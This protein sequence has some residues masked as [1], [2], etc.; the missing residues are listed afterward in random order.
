MKSSGSISPGLVH[1]NCGRRGQSWQ[2]NL[3]MFNKSL[4][5]VLLA[6]ELK[7][8][9]GHEKQLR[10]GTAWQGWSPWRE[11]TG[12]GTASPALESLAHLRCQSCGMNKD[13]CAAEPAWGYQAGWLD[14]RDRQRCG[15]AKAPRAQKIMSPGYR[16]ITLLEFGFAFIVTVPWF[17]LLGIRKV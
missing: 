8:W 2:A 16:V 7:N 6:W 13:R 10:P 3:V 17:F 9:R 15:T 4:L 14:D 5:H 12:E 1:R 11:V